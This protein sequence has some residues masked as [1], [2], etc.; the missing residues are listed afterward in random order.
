MSSQYTLE[1][2]RNGTTYDFTDMT[3]WSPESWSGFGMAPLHRLTERGP[4]QHGET[5]RGY[6]LD[7]RTI[8]LRLNINSA[9]LETAYDNRETMI[10]AFKPGDDPLLLRFTYPD[11]RTR[12]IACYLVDGVDLDTGYWSG[13]WQVIPVRLYC[14]DPVWYDPTGDA[15]SFELGGSAETGGEI[16]MVVPMFVGSSVLDSDVAVTYDGTWQEYPL[17]RIVGPI[18]NPKITNVTTDETLDFTGGTIAAG[19]WYDLDLRYGYKTIEDSTGAN[20]IADLSNDSDLVT[21]HL[22]ADP[23]AASGVNSITVTGT[24]VTLATTVHMTWFSRYI[25]V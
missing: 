2:I 10:A 24:G 21:W 25:G 5:D 17:I 7:A 15:Q 19:D 23:E 16:P 13:Y 20:Q 8:V 3:T 11:G 12:Q 1:I 9:D 6:R 14:P 4:M 18:T 22:A